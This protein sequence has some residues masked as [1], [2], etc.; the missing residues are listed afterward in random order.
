[1]EGRKKVKSMSF[2]QYS[3]NS[4][5]ETIWISLIGWHHKTS[6][7]YDLLYLHKEFCIFPANK[8]YHY[9]QFRFEVYCNNHRDWHLFFII[10]FGLCLRFWGFKKT[11]SNHFHSSYSNLLPY[12]SISSRSSTQVQCFKK[13]IHIQKVANNVIILSLSTY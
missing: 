8:S 11:Y 1:M 5:V 12:F 13:A 10:N 9:W 2:H 3:W 6:S 7:T 4:K